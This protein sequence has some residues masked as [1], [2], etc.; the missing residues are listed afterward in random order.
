MPA[1][2]GGD[3]GRSEPH[4]EQGSEVSNHRTTEPRKHEAP[5]HQAPKRMFRD[6]EI[7]MYGESHYPSKAPGT[8][9]PQAAPTS[10]PDERVLI[11]LSLRRVPV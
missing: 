10:E 5:K 6:T 7:Q 9:A 2:Q 1:C 11:M 3:G 8:L 4:E